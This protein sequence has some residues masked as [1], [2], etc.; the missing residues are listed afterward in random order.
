VVGPPRFIA[1]AEDSG[2]ILPIGLWV[3]S[4]ACR[5]IKAWHNAGHTGIRIS[6]NLSTRQFRQTDLIEN[7]TRILAETEVDGRF[8]GIEIT[9][10]LMIQD[11]ETVIATLNSMKALGIRTSI[12][13]FGTGYSS[14]SYLQQLPVDQVKIDKSFIQNVLTDPNDA[15]IAKAIVAMGQSL[16]LEVV[17]EGVE[18]IEQVEFLRSLSCD[19]VQGN[20]FFEPVPAKLIC[21][22]LAEM[23]VAGRQASLNESQH[24]FRHMAAYRSAPEVELKNAAAHEDSGPVLQ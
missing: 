16:H 9:E 22:F 7:I 14:L 2:L 1:V 11:R 17:A 12:D 8:L 20:Y 4:E 21:E 24:L 19:K 13:D 18:T 3:L 15:A 10:S 23:Q 6:V 5:Q